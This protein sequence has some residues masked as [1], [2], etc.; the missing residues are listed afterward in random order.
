MNICINKER[1]NAV[2]NDF[3]ALDKNDALPL[4]VKLHTLLC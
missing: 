3:L 1:C 4:S 2:C